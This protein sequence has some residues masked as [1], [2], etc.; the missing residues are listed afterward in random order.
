MLPTYVGFEK[1]DCIINKT[2]K[3]EANR[4]VTYSIEITHFIYLQT[5]L[6]HQIVH[7]LLESD[8]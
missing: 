2:E 8:A 3:I 5:V 4:V 7:L 1:R 6:V